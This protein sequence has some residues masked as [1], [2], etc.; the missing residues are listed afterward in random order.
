MSATL[1][2][3]ADAMRLDT[4]TAAPS[5]SP[6]GGDEMDFAVDAAPHS[7]LLSPTPRLEN[8]YVSY[9]DGEQQQQQQQQQQQRWQGAPHTIFL[10]IPL[11][12]ATIG[13][14]SG[15]NQVSP[16]P[17]LSP[18]RKTALAQVHVI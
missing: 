10:P 7:R 17:K 8:N 13:S 6:G 3:K 4:G 14:S 1:Q 5:T 15:R 9:E 12:T 18:G 11:N 2:D 16:S